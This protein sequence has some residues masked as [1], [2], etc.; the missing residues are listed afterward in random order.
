MEFDVEGEG[1]AEGGAGLVGAIES[2]VEA[3]EG[4]EG[5]EL[6]GGVVGDGDG[7]E[8]GFEVGEGLLGAGGARDWREDRRYHR[9]LYTPELLEGMVHFGG[10]GVAGGGIFPAG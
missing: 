8:F 9:R 2:G 6:G 3:D 4:T 10:A 5:R 7:G 1:L